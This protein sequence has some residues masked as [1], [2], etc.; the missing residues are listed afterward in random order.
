MSIVVN[1]EN[2][3]YN[4]FIIKTSLYSSAALPSL[5][6]SYSISYMGVQYLMKIHV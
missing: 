3:N 1:T 6:V 4:P 5:I 2:E